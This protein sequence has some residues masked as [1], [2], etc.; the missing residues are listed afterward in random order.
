MISI[1]T[2][3]VAPLH[4]RAWQKSITT[5]PHH[6]EGTVPDGGEDD[7]SKMHADGAKKMRE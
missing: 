4:Q 6:V 1:S 7:Q 5:P 2:L 3:P